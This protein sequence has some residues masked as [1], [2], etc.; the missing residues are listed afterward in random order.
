MNGSLYLYCSYLIQR[1]VPW[2]DML[3]CYV[4]ML[5]KVLDWFAKESS[6]LCHVPCQSAQQEVKFK[7]GCVVEVNSQ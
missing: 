7:K 4:H 5:V 1:P 3:T 2:T 6:S